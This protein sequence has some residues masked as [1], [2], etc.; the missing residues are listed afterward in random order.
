MTTLRIDLHVHSDD[1][2]DGHEPIDLILEHAADIGLDAVVVTDHDVMG[3]S[4]RAA[5]LAPEYG[6]VGIPG[7]EVSTAHGHLL[8]V[9]VDQMPPHR[10]PFDETV[11]WIRDHGGVAVV[12]HPF[13]RSRHGVRRRYVGDCDAIEVFNAWLFTGYRNRRA[14]QFAVEHGYPGVAASDA[15]TLEYVGRAFSEID[16]GDVSREAVTSEHVLEAIRDGETSVRGRRAPIPMASKHYAIAAARKSAYY[17]KKSVK[18]S[19]TYA[20]ASAIK[21]ASAAKLGAIRGRHGL[22]RIVSLFE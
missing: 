16:V 1:S 14:R 21:T 13:Q 6:L 22:S 11:A 3:E 15:H 18:T 2:Y 12:P 20:K 7:V 10:K 4:I 5:E 9:G 17:S 19:A 8:A